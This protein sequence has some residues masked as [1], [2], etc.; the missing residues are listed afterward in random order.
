MADGRID[1]WG[2]WGTEDERGA[3]NLQT[4]ESVLAAMRSSRSG[5]VYQLGLPVQ[6]TGV[7]NVAYRNPPQRLTL[8]NQSDEDM[9]IAYGGVPGTGSN[10]DVIVMATHSVTHIDALSHV[11]TDRSMYNGFPHDSF[12]ANGGASRCGIEKAGPIVTRG[13]LLDVAAEQGVDGLAPGA[14]VGA[15]DLQRAM[16]RQG[17]EVEAGDA[18]LIRTGWLEAYGRT[19]VMT[20]D[21]PGI[22]HEA[23]VFL[24]ERDVMVVGSDNTAL[25]AMP[26]PEGDFMPVHIELLSRRG[27]YLIE[28]LVLDQLAA[29]RCHE[30]L[31]CAIPLPITGATGSP[32]NPIAIA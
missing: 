9:L 24:A 5:R 22:G 2:R 16:D 29:D 4:Q 7:P 26:F 27:V 8:L 17:V 19:G 28:H 6:R 25:E 12:S 14:V 20:L 3:L 15:D 1:N 32:V 21:Q 18:V 11:Y 13:V 31:F 23:A 30:F 10:E